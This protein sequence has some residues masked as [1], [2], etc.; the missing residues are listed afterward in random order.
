MKTKTV[1]TILVVVA[2]I[3]VA[4]LLFAPKT[5]DNYGNTL[6]N[7]EEVIADQEAA[8]ENLTDSEILNAEVD[9]GELYD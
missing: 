9:I 1:I 4:F 2:L 5:N 7:N 8:N 3:V 6:T